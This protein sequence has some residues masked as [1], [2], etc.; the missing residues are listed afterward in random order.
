MDFLLPLLVPDL[1]IAGLDD[2]V[3]VELARDLASESRVRAVTRRMSKGVVI[4]KLFSVLAILGSV[5]GLSGCVADM[6]SSS[7]Q[8]DDVE[9]DEQTTPCTTANRSVGDAASGPPEPA[10]PH[11][12]S[13]Y[14]SSR[15]RRGRPPLRTRRDR[16]APRADQF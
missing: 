14:D 5:F 8:G 6:D 12:P 9:V 10:S 7:D 15:G 1:Q 13:S 16:G 11:E 3:Q 2:P 4:M